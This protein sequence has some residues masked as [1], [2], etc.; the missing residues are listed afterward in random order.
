MSKANMV[1]SIIT[2][3][4]NNAAGLKKTFE[5]VF[6][7]SKMDFSQLEYIVIDGDSSDESIEIIKTYSKHAKVKGLKFYWK[8]EVDSG[9]YNAMN[10]GIIKAKGDFCLFLNSGD[11]L[12]SNQIISRL[13]KDVKKQSIY[14]SDV[15]YVNGNHFCGL[16]HYSDSIDDRF[17]YSGSSIN[18]QNCL[19]PLHLLKKYKGYDESYKIKAD[20]LFFLKI[21]FNKECEYAHLPYIISCYDTSGISANNDE[22]CKEEWARGIQQIYG[23]YSAD[24]IDLHNYKNSDYAKLLQ[25]LDKPAFFLKFINILYRIIRKL[26]K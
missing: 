1:I 25:L 10:K 18:H 3:N 24:I 20:W 4:K 5:S 17:F 2:I 8:S 14:F 22:L 16:M 11:Y 15:Q 12:I 26:K 13:Q 6:S 23:D 9:V 21:A 19:I 7:Q